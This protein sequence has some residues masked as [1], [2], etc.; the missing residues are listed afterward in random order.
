MRS[1]QSRKPYAFGSCLMHRRIVSTNC[2]RLWSESNSRCVVSSAKLKS[3]KTKLR[4]I[5]K[6]SGWSTGRTSPPN[7]QSRCGCNSA[8]RHNRWIKKG[9]HLTALARGIFKCRCLFIK[10]FNRAFD[11][12]QQR[13]TTAV[14]RLGRGHFHPPFADAIF[15]DIK[16]FFA[17]DANTDVVLENIGVV[18]LTA[19][20][21]AQA[22]WQ[23]WA[24]FWGR[25]IVHHYLLLW[26]QK[27]VI[28]GVKPSLLKGSVLELRTELPSSLSKNQEG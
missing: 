1:K 5:N 4:K 26:V 11:G 23:G 18:K 2:C 17:V 16:T 10:G 22:I 12:Q 15:I 24:I 25:G 28:V 13:L 8:L 19:R 27:S 21:G 6:G 20:I 7:K 14:E 9:R 3:A